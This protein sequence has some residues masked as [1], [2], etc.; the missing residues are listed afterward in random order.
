MLSPNATFP[1]A[2]VST[3]YPPWMG[4]AFAGSAMVLPSLLPVAIERQVVRV[5]Q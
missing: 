1:K 2:V 5:S 4:S 3:T